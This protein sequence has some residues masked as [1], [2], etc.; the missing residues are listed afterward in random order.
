MKEIQM[1]EEKLQNVNIEDVDERSDI[2]SR[3]QTILKKQETM[4]SDQSYLSPTRIKKSGTFL[5]K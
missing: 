2:L 3:M 4:I 1:I 5:S